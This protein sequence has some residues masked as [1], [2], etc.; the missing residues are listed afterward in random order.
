M[1]FCKQCTPAVPEPVTASCTSC[2]AGTFLVDTATSATKHDESG[3]CTSCIAGKWK[4]AVE[5]A[6]YARDFGWIR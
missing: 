6:D 4:D 3:D 5:W 1:C 2:A